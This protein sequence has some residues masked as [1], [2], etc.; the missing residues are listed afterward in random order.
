MQAVKFFKNFCASPRLQKNSKART[1]YNPTFLR[2]TSLIPVSHTINFVEFNL[3]EES[4]ERD[5]YPSAHSKRFLLAQRN[6]R[7]ETG[8]RPRIRRRVF[9]GQR[10]PRSET[11]IR[12]YI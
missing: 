5:R 7:S 1:E 10:N 4:T 6:P 2:V 3:S 9:G 8:I 12:S 11:S